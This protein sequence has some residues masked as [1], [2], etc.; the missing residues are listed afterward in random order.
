MT[1]EEIKRKYAKLL[2]DVET[3]DFYKVDLS[4]RVNCYVCKC[5]HITKTKDID[6]GVTPFMFG[7]EQ[8]GEFSQ[9]SMYRDVAPYLE[10]TIE[11]YRPSLEEVFKMKPAMADHILRGGLAHRK[12]PKDIQPIKAA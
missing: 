11:W 4:N 6:A 9:S 3:K 10:P 12:I 8:C 5:G 2:K 1:R 7:C